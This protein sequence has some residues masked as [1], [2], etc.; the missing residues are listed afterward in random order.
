MAPARATARVSIVPKSEDT[1]PGNLIL[2][3]SIANQLLEA[4]ASTASQASEQVLAELVEHFALHHSFLR[5]NANDL[6]V[7]R[8]IIGFAEAFNLQLVAEGVETPSTALA[9]MR[10]GCHRAQGYLL[11]RPIASSAMESLLTSH[12]LP[13]P[14]LADSE[15]LVRAVT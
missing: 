2:I 5:Y 10:N 8:A 1:V 13:M 7:V 4:T 12:Y 14:F 6:V 15:A 3:T 9:L 11:S